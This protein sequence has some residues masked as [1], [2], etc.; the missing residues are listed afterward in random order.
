MEPETGNETSG[1]QEPNEKRSI[2]RNVCHTHGD[3]EMHGVVPREQSR[4]I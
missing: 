1:T 4:V 3:A 2:H